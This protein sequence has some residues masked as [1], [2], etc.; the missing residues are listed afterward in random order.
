MSNLTERL[1]ALSRS[2]HDDL[3]IAGEAADRIG[4]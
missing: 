4:G 1:R 2:E 3:S